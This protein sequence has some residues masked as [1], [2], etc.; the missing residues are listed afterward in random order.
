MMQI[1]G[2]LEYL[3]ISNI[4]NLNSKLSNNEFWKALG[5]FRSIKWMNF[6]NSGDMDS[7]VCH[8]MGRAVAFNARN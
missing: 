4:S 1:N 7:S 5:E 6:S 2:S 3:N 8:N